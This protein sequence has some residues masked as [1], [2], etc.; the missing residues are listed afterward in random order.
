MISDDGLRLAVERG[1]LTPDQVAG[2]RALEQERAS[3]GA[4]PQDPEA[5]RFITGFAD[6]FVTIGIGLF[7]GAAGWFVA[8]T[9]S[10][11]L[12]GA[13]V[14]G[15]AWALAEFFT[16]RRRMALPSIVLLVVWTA[17]VFM[18]IA[19]LLGGLVEG[20]EARP[21]DIAG[22]LAAAGLGAAL[23]AA[24]HYWRF[25]V[26]ITVAAGF[27]A[28]AGAALATLTAVAPD[29]AREARNVLFLACGLLAFALAMRFDLSDRQRVTRRTDIAFWLHLLAAPLIV[30]PLVLLVFGP[31][32]AREGV[33]PA[34]AAG[35]VRPAC[36]DRAA[37]GPPGA[38][39]VGAGVRG[40]G[41][42]EPASRLGDPGRDRAHDA[43]GAGRPGAAAQR[44]LAAD[45]SRGADPGARG[46]SRPP[47]AC[48][49]DEPGGGVANQRRF[50]TEG[51]EGARR[52]R[53]P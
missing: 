23:G 6:V 50:I 41:L 52:T 44:R 42:V 2:L 35:A 37:G 39:G 16:R 38:A 27:A 10:A 32:G 33:A 7:L 5:F 47:A 53:R 34:S 4:E 31:E 20:S 1:L 11:A 8:R 45:P 21:E 14:A 29:F 30:H 15:L 9:D 26:P 40:L 13:V 24:A 43:A 25:R 18:T 22:P 28:L 3:A 12:T 19:A 17:A 49:G 36:R 48:G 51:T 46:L